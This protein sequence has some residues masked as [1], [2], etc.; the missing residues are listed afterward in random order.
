MY[1]PST[2]FVSRDNFPL[3]VT[4]SHLEF[5]FVLYPY[6]RQ[7]TTIELSEINQSSISEIYQLTENKDELDF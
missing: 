3:P 5:L 6:F 2:N 7:P 1:P 4:I